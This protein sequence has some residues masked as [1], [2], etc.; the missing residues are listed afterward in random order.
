VEYIV[1][2]NFYSLKDEKLLWSG[3]SASGNPKKLDN[4]VKDVAKEVVNKMREDK[5]ITGK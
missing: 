1:S 5:F 2:S 4:L 3:V